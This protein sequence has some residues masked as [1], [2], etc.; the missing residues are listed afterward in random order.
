MFMTNSHSVYAYAADRTI[1]YEEWTNP[2]FIEERFS[3]ATIQYSKG[4]EVIEKP[5]GKR[6][7]VLEE[8]LPLVPTIY[9]F[10]S[11]YP[12]LANTAFYKSSIISIE[13]F[14]KKV[15]GAISSSPNSNVFNSNCTRPCET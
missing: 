13:K 10:I 11:R 5:E 6:V 15:K 2:T 7:D 12:G 1:D 4:F 14:A 9:I 8:N 3:A